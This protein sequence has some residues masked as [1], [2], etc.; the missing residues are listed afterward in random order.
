MSEDLVS[1][2][3]KD[4]CSCNEAYT[5][6]QLQDPSCESC[7]TADD[8]YEAAAVIQALRIKVSHLQ[9]AFYGIKVGTKV[10]LDSEQTLPALRLALETCL[11]IAEEAVG[12]ETPRL[13]YPTTCGACG[14]GWV[15]GAA[16]DFC[17]C[18]EP[19]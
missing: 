14:M 1:R 12:K 9:A 2:L 11:E 18:G 15:S 19:L 6:R 4:Y 10:A 8:R 16:I 13:L 7:N 3:A 17:R 5:S